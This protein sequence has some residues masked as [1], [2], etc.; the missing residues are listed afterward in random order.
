MLS[1]DH[2]RR[3]SHRKRQMPQLGGHRGCS[4]FTVLA[5]APGQDHERLVRRVHAHRDAGPQI[6][7]RLPGTGD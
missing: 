6:R 5:G 3:L 1:G 7:H 4:L 2:R